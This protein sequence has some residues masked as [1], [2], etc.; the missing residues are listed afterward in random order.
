MQKE[1]KTKL[2]QKLGISRGMIYYQHKREIIDNEIK[3]KILGVLSNHPAYGHKRIAPELSLNK[4]RILR[5]M[6]LYGIKPYKRRVK[7]DK[8]E[9]Q[10]KPP[11]HFTNLI[12]S[13][14]PICPNVVWVG[15]FTYI[16]FQGRFFY[17]ATV[18]DLYTREVIGWN[19]S[20][21]HDKELVMGA[22]RDALK[23]TGTNPIY[24]HCDQGSEYDSLDF[25]SLVELSGVKL[26]MSTKASP[27]ENGFQE[28]Y[29]SNFKLELGNPN[30]FND[31]GELIEAI[32][33]T[34]YYY[35]H[36]RIHT[37][38]KMPP[39]LF[40]LSYQQ[41]SREYLFKEMGAWH[42][43]KSQL[44]CVTANSPLE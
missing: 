13:F 10:N 30:R 42:I 6:N 14:C 43:A 26:S 8:P 37:K 9:D 34:I 3:E 32:A 39:E 27:W 5:V 7:P 19:I 1:N 16:S 11:T 44:G 15:D 35:N 2:A 36:K 22:F 25:I 41:R 17:L 4:K 31:L 29:Y 28:S 40:K 23:K 38:L 33:Q 21:N 12:K 20:V 24:F 18:I